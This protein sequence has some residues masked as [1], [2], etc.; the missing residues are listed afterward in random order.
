MHFTF[1]KEKEET[2]VALR[3]LHHIKQEIITVFR[4]PKKSP[5][6][7]DK[8]SI[9]VRPHWGKSLD[10]SCDDFITF[11]CSHHMKN[12]SLQPI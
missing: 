2:P 9:D 5:G 1:C 8:T 7:L 11:S 12:H 6:E 4:S 3:N 10:T